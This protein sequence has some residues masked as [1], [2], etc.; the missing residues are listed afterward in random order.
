MT[1]PGERDHSSAEDLDEDRLSLDPL[2]AGMDPP[3]HWSEADRFG[4]TA[5]EQRQG[6]DLEH[7][8]REEEPDTP[9]DGPGAAVDPD[10]IP[11]DELDD[12]IDGIT[13][14]PLPDEYSHISTAVQRG[15]SADE[16]GGS[17]AE[18]IRTP[19]ERPE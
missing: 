13:I 3:E 9:P 1:D 17:M 15:Q 8:L 4:T 7:R 11:D 5:A 6:Q 12:S 10:D 18:E 14:E 2:E 19:H 16:A